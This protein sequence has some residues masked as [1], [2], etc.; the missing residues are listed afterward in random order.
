V[1]SDVKFLPGRSQRRARTASAAELGE[2]M[3]KLDAALTSIFTENGKRTI[4]YYMSERY[5]L[6]LEAASVDPSKLERAMTSLL[7]EIGWMTVKR[8][9]LE[10]F[11]ERRIEDRET[12]VVLSA[13]LSEAF[14]FARSFRFLSL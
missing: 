8:S 1:L 12:R 13:S 11:W 6:T 14:G 3:Q 10:Q 5:G 4:M 7:G 9:I 2:V